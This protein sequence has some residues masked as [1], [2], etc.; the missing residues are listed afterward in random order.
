MGVRLSMYKVDDEIKRDI[1]KLG[2]G[3]AFENI[4]IYLTNSCS[5]NC[6]HCYLGNRLTTRDEMPIESVFEHLETWRA[7]GSEKICFIGGEPTLYPYLNEAIDRAKELSYK[8]IIVGS[9]GSSQARKVFE[10]LPLEK[11]S[12]IQISL[13]GATEKT[14]DT[15]RRKGA[16]SDAIKTINELRSHNVDVRIIMTVNQYNA[17]EVIPMIQLGEKLGVSLTKFHIM[18]K[19][20]NAH[21]SIL[22][23]ISPEEWLACCNSIVDYC[24]KDVKRSMSVS[25]Q[26]AYEHRGKPI[27]SYAG[28]LGKN[29]E[30]ISVFPDGRCYI[31]SF[32]FDYD[33]FYAYLHSG[34]IVKN[35]KNEYEMFNNTNC[36]NCNNKCIY[37]GCIAEEITS[38]YDFCKMYP[39]L[40]PVCRLWK[41]EL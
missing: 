33:I 21:D 8:T 11:L 13:D 22:K 18:S 5:Y 14:H 35:T 40:Y 28:C 27:K 4:Y 39:T 15:I 41:Y 17:N 23:P 20:G 34:V 9:N 38:G 12:Y 7:L 37:D 32:L 10:S 31:C 24:K 1:S 16:Y 36:D 19:I 3:K 26:P 30:R 29:L 6:S 2:R 25:F